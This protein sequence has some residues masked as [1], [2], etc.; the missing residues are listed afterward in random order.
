MESVT[1]VYRHIVAQASDTGGPPT[2]DSDNEV[3][4]E[5]FWDEEGVGLADDVIGI[6][7]GVG[8]VYDDIDVDDVRIRKRSR[9]VDNDDDDDNA[10]GDDEDEDG[11]DDDTVDE[12]PEF[13]DIPDLA[14]IE[15][16]ADFDGPPRYPEFVG[17]NTWPEED[18]QDF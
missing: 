8:G 13:A 15:E 17:R 3:M 1:E 9:K 11:G 18:D 10:D 16:D 7:R 14:D 12:D 4:S 6:D 5:E 2:G